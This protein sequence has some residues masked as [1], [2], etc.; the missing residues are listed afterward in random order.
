[1][2]GDAAT[3]CGVLL[4]VRVVQ[5]DSQIHRISTRERAVGAATD[6]ELPAVVKV[7]EELEVPWA[8]RNVH[9]AVICELVQAK[10]RSEESLEAQ[11]SKALDLLA[12]ND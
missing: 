11:H 12:Q 6:C 3:L 7:K 10:D 2:D 5:S 9:C 8:R 1:V 4:P